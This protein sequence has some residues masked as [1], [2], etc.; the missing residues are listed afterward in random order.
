MTAKKNNFSNAN[1]KTAP[2]SSKNVVP[3]RKTAQH[4]VARRTASEVAGFKIITR[5]K[6]GD[7]KPFPHAAVFAAVC[8]TVLFLFMMINYISLEKLNDEVLENNNTINRLVKE[9]SGLED[10]RAKRDN[11]DEITKYAVNELGM[12]KGAEKGEYIDIHPRDNININYYEDENENTLGV[13]LT[14]AGNVIKSFFTD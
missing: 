3:A 13:L 8:F 11:L 2:A 6:Y 14:G 1:K 12:V 5:K 10:K 9:K 4:P 7:K